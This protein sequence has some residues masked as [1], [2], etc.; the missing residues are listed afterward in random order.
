LTYGPTIFLANDVEK[1][2][3]FC[4]QQANIPGE[5]MKDIRDKIE[6][7]NN[8]N[9]EI[10]VLEKDLEDALQRNATL[11]AD[12]GKQ[13]LTVYEDKNSK[14]ITGKLEQLRSLIKTAQLNETFVPNKPM[15]LK[16][17]YDGD[18]A[19]TKAFTCDIDESHISE[20][21]LLQDVNDS[22]KI[23]LMMGIGVFADHKSIKYTEIM[24]KL[25]DEQKLTV[26]IASSDFIYGT[27]YQFC[28]GYLSKDMCVTQ[29]K[30]I[31]SLG[32]IGRNTIYQENSIRLRDE[33]QIRR[34]FYEEVDKIEVANMNRLFC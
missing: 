31:Q 10:A 27:N 12:D 32:R 7:N 19:A 15:H 24:K 2:A 23:L 6:F 22:W 20:I 18:S 30:I 25:A 3:K 26:I 34:L 14:Q 5:V 4:I 11:R 13:Q 8:V 28:H 9:E 33:E 16:K 17:W 29:E 1:I 21:M